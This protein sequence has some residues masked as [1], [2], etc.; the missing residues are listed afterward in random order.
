M[1]AGVFGRRLMYVS[2]DTDQ[3]QHFWN[4]LGQL[5]EINQQSYW[6]IIRMKPKICWTEMMSGRRKNTVSGASTLGFLSC[7]VLGGWPWANILG[8]ES[9]AFK[10][11]S[12]PDSSLRSF[13][14]YL[15]VVL[16]SFDTDSFS[17]CKMKSLTI[18]TWQLGW[19]QLLPHKYSQDVFGVWVQV[20]NSWEP[21][22]PNPQTHKE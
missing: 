16:K 4:A 3:S 21:R 1:A 10:M 13:Q 15:S 11:K 6:N 9:F 17:C 5:K 8:H 12:W 14:V 18:P 7:F 19:V 2:H 20:W 22:R